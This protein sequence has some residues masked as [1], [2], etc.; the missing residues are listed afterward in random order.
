MPKW[1]QSGF[2]DSI[3]ASFDTVDSGALDEAVLIKVNKKNPSCKKGGRKEPDKLYKI[4]LLNVQKIKVC[5]KNFV[6]FY[7]SHCLLLLAVLLH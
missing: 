5:V 4:Q 1:Q 2:D 6:I 3:P 7:I